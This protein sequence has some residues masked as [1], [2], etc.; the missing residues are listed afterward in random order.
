MYVIG[1]EDQE[2][3]EFKNCAHRGCDAS[4][5]REANE[6]VDDSLRGLKAVLPRRE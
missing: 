3:D 1:G 5:D 4:F 6:T 2:H